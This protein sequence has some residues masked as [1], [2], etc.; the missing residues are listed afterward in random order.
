MIV[1]KYYEDLHTL[2]ENTIPNRAYFIPASRRMDDLVEN[3]EH[4][5]RMQL[6]S[7]IWDFKFYESIYDLQEPFYEMGFP[8]DDYRGILVPG[9]W[10]THGYDVH[11]YTNIRFPIPFDPP[12]VPQD[13]P[14]GAYIYEFDYTKDADA[15]KAYLN[16]EGVDSCF[17]VWL[18]GHYVGYS[19]V[20]HS[21]SEFDVTPYLAEGKNKLAVLVLKWC[22][23]TY[24]E[25][26]DKFRMSGIF[27][28]VYLL[29]RPEKHI[30]DYAVTTTLTDALI[31]LKTETEVCVS[32]Y[33]GEV[34]LAQN[35]TR[36][37]TRLHL[38]HPRQWNAETPNLYTLVL[39]TEGEVIT[40]RIGFRE[41]A[42]RDKVVTLNGQPIKFRG[43][44]RHDS[45]PVTGF[46]ISLEQ[47]KRD[48]LLMKQHNV[49]AIRTSHYPNAPVFYQ[50]CD[51]YGFYVIDESDNESHGTNELM[52]KNHDWESYMEIWSKPIADNP[53]FLDAIL[54]RTQRLV[55][56]DKNRPCVVIWSMGNE[57]GFGCNFEAALRWTKETDPSRLT[58]YE[59]ARYVPK[60]RKSD[61]SNLDLYSRMYPSDFEMNEYLNS[62]PD[63]PLILCEYAH[64]MGN[65]PGD[66][67]DYFRMFD[68][69][70]IMCGGFVWEWC[71]HAIYKGDAENGKPI[72]FYGGDHGEDQHDGNF[73]MDGLVYPDR[74]PHTGLLELKNVQRPARIA[75]IDQNA[76]V[77]TLK[78]HL[79]FVNLREYLTARY[80]ITCDGVT[81]ASGEVEIPS[82]V[83]HGM[84]EIPV[85]MH[86]PEKGKCFLKLSYFLKKA[87]DLLPQGHSLGFD[88]VALENGDGRNQ[89][90]LSLGREGT[91]AVNVEESDRYLTV[92]GEGFVYT[93]NKLTGLWESL[94][95]GGR[96]LLERPMELNTWRAPTD[97]D[98]YIKSLWIR[99]YYDKTRA[100]AYE[101]SWESDETG[102]VIR[103]TLSVSAITIQR[104]LTGSITWKVSASGVISMDLSMTRDGEFTMLPRFGIR[105]FLPKTMDQVKYFGLGPMENYRDKC[106]AASHGIYESSVSGLHEDYLMPQENGAHG[107]CDY[108]ILKG[109]DTTLAV[110]GEKTF[111]FNASHYTQEELT[112]KQHSFELE[113][114]GST[115]LCI[116]YAHTGIG[117]NSCGPGLRDQYQLT[118]ERIAFQVRLIPS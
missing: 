7:G 9:M 75:A 118:D 6:L 72:Y 96:A 3:R 20:S 29:K 79:D 48:L 90:A 106:R 57:G 115:V 93:Y 97:N 71:D 36:D 114:C 43:V 74:R 70:D 63:K 18:N 116:D 23:G 52:Q 42:I 2:H 91:G 88:E 39:E 51:Q 1:P 34:L 17:Y 33:D 107:D 66:L 8:R 112:E 53:E 102:L 108:V 24:L 50:L 5:D 76:R 95:Y 67:E 89:T 12:Y 56:R 117:S 49:N 10:Q 113:E 31:Q 16:F 65:G 86:V 22:D 47:M 81:A 103:S 73:C 58:H 14:C 35:K 87:T 59:A 37:M 28:D 92:S 105:M 109:T 94:H 41:I 100:R 44:N 30:Q 98:R 27:R 45:D 64:A 32:I 21:T 80:E 83:P 19:Q 26:Q 110:T 55:H 68:K 11:Q 61:Y 101:T 13:N 104:I 77:V 82:I 111:T 69:H 54:D 62:N 25:D 38:D 46:A 99:S 4:S 15:P 84:G 60:A 78:N 85:P 40:D